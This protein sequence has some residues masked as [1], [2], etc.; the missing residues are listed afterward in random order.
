MRFIFD[1]KIV[2]IIAAIAIAVFFV[3]GAMAAVPF[4]GP[5]V[6]CGGSGQPPCQDICQLFELGKN[7][8]DF[9]ITISFA[10]AVI[11]IVWAGFLML[12][13]TL[14][15]ESATMYAK[16]RKVLVQAFIGMAII[17]LAWLTIDAVIKILA[18]QT[19]ADGQ[20]ARIGG[21]G[22]WNE[23]NCNLAVSLTTP[24]APQP[25]TPTPPPSACSIL[26]L[27]PIT[28]P[29]A[30]QM[31]NGN[32]VIWEK[33]DPRLKPCV[34]RFISK[35]GGRVTSAYRPEPYQTHL[36]EI[37][38]RWCTQGLRSNTDPACVS[39]KNTVQQEVTK[40]FGSNWNCG[41]VGQ[42]SRHT[43]GTGVDI[44]GITHGSAAVQQAASES[45]LEWKNY[46]GDPYH[47]DLKQGCTC[48]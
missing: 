20:V 3:S 31:E 42:T 38:D 21:Y 27:S 2:L 26:P 23:I 17:F 44:S 22:P 35:V 13:P 30:Q 8:F 7:I 45:C 48:Q 18:G 19:L 11:M 34:D 5:I 41:L 15:G 25:S 24:G 4:S 14:G 39:L 36:F 47:Y 16:G 46:A 9:I 32:T 33:T 6:P 12:M 37:R 43:S 10:I 28:D 29:L 1:K 40:H